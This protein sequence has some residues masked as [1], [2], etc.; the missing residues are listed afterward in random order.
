MYYESIACINIKH[1]SAYSSVNRLPFIIWNWKT[2]M[3]LQMFENTNLN[4]QI[5][6]QEPITLIL[7]YE[8]I[9]HVTVKIYTNTLYIYREYIWWALSLVSKNCAM[10]I[11]HS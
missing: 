4:L 5:L 2:T 11:L 8:Q 7:A 10:C 6:W 1:C 3:F 9:E